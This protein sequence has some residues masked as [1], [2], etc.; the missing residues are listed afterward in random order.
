[1]RTEE[2]ETAGEGW[3]VGRPTKT[4]LMRV[5]KPFVDLPS[6]PPF[7]N[8]TTITETIAL[9]EHQIYCDGLSRTLAHY[10]Q[11]WAANGKQRAWQTFAAA[12]PKLWPS[13]EIPSV[14]PVRSEPGVKLS[15]KLA[16]IDCMKEYGETPFSPLNGTEAW[17]RDD[18]RV[19]DVVEVVVEEEPVSPVASIE[20]EYDD[21]DDAGGKDGE[22]TG[23][24]GEDDSHVIDD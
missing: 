9:V 19:W 1:M 5:C 13:G 16:T 3:R 21:N 23:D 24:S 12:L 22:G 7:S 20:E 8:P 4:Q 2:K 15:V 6:S 17:T 14:P 10:R 18:D 11:K